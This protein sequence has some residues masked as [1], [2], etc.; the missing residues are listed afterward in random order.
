[1]KNQS[2]GFYFVNLI[3]CN[4]K[5]II[6]RTLLKYSKRH[7]FSFSC[8]TQKESTK[9]QDRTVRMRKIYQL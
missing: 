1:M 9:S 5:Y 4:Y 3:N 8:G 6:C 2:D 7:N